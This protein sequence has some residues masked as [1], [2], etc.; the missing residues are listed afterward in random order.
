MKHFIAGALI[1]LSFALGGCTT[2]ASGLDTLATDL[3]SSSP[4]QVTTYYDATAAADLATKTVDLAVKTMKFNRATL[5]E[6]QS[7]NDSLHT[8][9]LVLKAANDANQSLDYAAFNAAL[10]AYQS[11]RVSQAIPEATATPTT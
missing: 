1:A 2:I 4:T 9:W 3:S 11:Y 8:A 5:T 10:A 6:L 7:L